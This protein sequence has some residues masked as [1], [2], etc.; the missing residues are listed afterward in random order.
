[1]ESEGGHL[2]AERDGLLKSQSKLMRKVHRLSTVLA[3]YADR[4]QRLSYEI[5]RLEDA[6][7]EVHRYPHAAKEIASRTIPKR[8]HRDSL[9]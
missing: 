5:R 4:N 1:M 8:I 6:L 7:S 2:Q 9:H 3:E